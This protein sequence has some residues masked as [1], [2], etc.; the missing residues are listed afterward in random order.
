MPK[1]VTEAEKQRVKELMFYSA[2]DL[3]K[4]KG[5]RKITV[6]DLTRESGISKGSFYMYYKSREE[7]LYEVLKRS[8]SDMFNSMI[9]LKNDKCTKEEKIKKALHD[10]YLA[11]GSLILYITPGDYKSLLKRLPGEIYE[12]EKQKSD[13]YFELAMNLFEIDPKSLNMSVLAQLMDSLIFVAN[14]NSNNYADGRERALEIIINSIA[15]YIVS[16]S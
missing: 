10:I 11:K 5:L 9:L 6:E 7:L 14:N 1:I 16:K 8:E 3:I 12:K 13:N 15:D 2:I 4:S